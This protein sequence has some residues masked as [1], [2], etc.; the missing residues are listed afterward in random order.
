MSTSDNNNN[1]TSTP[2]NNTS[3]PN[4]FACF[5]K[6]II[7]LLSIII[8]LFVVIA[9]KLSVSGDLFY[10]AFFSALIVISMICVTDLVEKWMTLEYEAQRQK[11]LLEMR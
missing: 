11:H 5:L 7:G 8:L 9:Y 6:I 2:N 1:N 4:S 3:T 10:I